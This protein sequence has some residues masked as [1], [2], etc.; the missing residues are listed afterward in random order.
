MKR[1]F[2]R[3][4][5]C[6][7]DARLGQ[8]RPGDDLC[9]FALIVRCV[10]ATIERGFLDRSLQTLLDNPRL[11]HDCVAVLLFTSQQMRV[12]D[13]ARRVLVD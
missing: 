12:R 1:R 8:T 3:L 11:R 7:F 6:L 4:D 2:R 9:Q 10:E 13:E 5:R